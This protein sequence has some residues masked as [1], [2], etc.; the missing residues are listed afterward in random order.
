MAELP[1]P[2]APWGVNDDGDIADEGGELVAINPRQ[3]NFPAH[4]IAAAPE[5]Y[6]ALRDAANALRFH[7]DS[8]THHGSSPELRQKQAVVMEQA[9]KA[10]AAIAKAR[11]EAVSNG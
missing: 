7:A 10:F 6:E 11:G 8:I 5:L 1:P 4:L 9:D 3:G 2:A